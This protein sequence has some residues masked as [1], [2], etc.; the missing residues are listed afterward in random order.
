MKMC[1]KI[2]PF[3]CIDCVKTFSCKS[4]LTRH[5][6][7]CI[8]RVKRVIKEDF[9][10]I[11]SKKDKETDMVIVKIT[12]T[13]DIKLE[14]K[15]SIIEELR[16]R[17]KELTK[18]LA[19]KPTVVHNTNTNI[20]VQNNFIKANFK[21]IT[22]QVLQDS[23]QHF[24]LNHV[25]NG[26]DGLARFALKYQLQDTRMLCTDFSRMIFKYLESPDRVLKDPYLKNFCPLFFT[27]IKDANKHLIDKLIKKIDL[28]VGD[29]DNLKE[30]IKYNNMIK[31]VNFSAEGDDTLTS[32]TFIRALGKSTVYSKV[33]QG[34]L[35]TGI[36]KITKM[37][38]IKKL[39]IKK[40]KLV[41]YEELRETIFEIEN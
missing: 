36:T 33:K 32:R 12:K 15:E 23:V 22:I 13:Y 5:I 24:T 10:K 18:L 1:I 29:E 20:N 6:K 27:A 8:I 35:A 3:L 31:D 2:K 28:D 40:N 37:I 16:E 7:S 38:Q 26:G 4:S 17:V 39:R 9:T 14:E 25:L 41:R 21:P 19:S 11:I 34:Q 30:L